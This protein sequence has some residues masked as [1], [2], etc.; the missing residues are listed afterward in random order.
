M[1]NNG[2]E[3]SGKECDHHLLLTRVDGSHIDI[4]VTHYTRKEVSSAQ[5][6]HHTFRRIKKC[7]NISMRRPIDCGKDCRPVCTDSIS[8][9]LLLEQH[10][11]NTSAG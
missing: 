7:S 5:G 9:S 8:M 3:V 6:R 1:F 11:D 10:S 4:K 2:L